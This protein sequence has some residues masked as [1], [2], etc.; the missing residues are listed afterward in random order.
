[1]PGKFLPLLLTKCHAAITR[2]LAIHK[3]DGGQD[4]GPN[5]PSRSPTF[6]MIVSK[7]GT[8]G[9]IDLKPSRG[10]IEDK[11]GRSKRI[12]LMQLQ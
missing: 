1:M 8:N 9:H 10:S 6:L 5:I 2:F 12:I 4:K 11:F 7:G 3:A